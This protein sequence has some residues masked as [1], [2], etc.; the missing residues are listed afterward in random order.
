MDPSAQVSPL[1]ATSTGKI[2]SPLRSRY[3]QLA[4]LARNLRRASSLEDLAVDGFCVKV[5]LK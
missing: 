4:R 2:S 1:L 5:L 3:P